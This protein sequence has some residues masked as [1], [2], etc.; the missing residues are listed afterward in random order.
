MANLSWKAK[1]DKDWILLNNQTGEIIGEGDMTVS[2]KLLPSTTLNDT[3]TGGTVTFTCTSCE[4]ETIKKIN[5]IRCPVTECEIKDI[6]TDYSKK[7][8]IT[9]GKCDTSVSTSIT[10]TT[11]TTYVTNGCNNSIEDTVVD[12]TLTDIPIDGLSH[13]YL[14]NGGVVTEVD[15]TERANIIVNREAGS[16]EPDVCKCEDF[17]DEG[18]SPAVVWATN[19]ESLPCEGGTFTACT[20]DK[21]TCVTDIGG[22][23]QISWATGFT[24]N[25]GEITFDVYR[26]TGSEREG[27]VYISFKANGIPC[28]VLGHVIKQAG[29][30]AP[31]C[32]ESH[33]EIP[34]GEI[35]TD[36]TTCKTTIQVNYILD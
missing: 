15:D 9:I 2:I 35:V 26:N 32:P 13:Y 11:T 3:D 29:S 1:A 22:L 5:V 31:V 12:I 27:M 33:L 36:P 7:T 34:E 24:T 4:G 8:T 21:S 17:S 28:T 23:A 10:Y 30:C 14:Y 25:N 18:E 20:Y 6:T 19:L 16:C